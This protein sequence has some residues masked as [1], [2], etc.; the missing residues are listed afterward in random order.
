M[1]MFQNIKI[2]KQ[3][4]LIINHHYTYNSFKI[5]FIKNL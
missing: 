2:T 5:I 4:I 1:M 3:E